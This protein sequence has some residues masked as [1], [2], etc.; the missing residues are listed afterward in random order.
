MDLTRAELDVVVRRREYAADDVV[1]LTLADPRGAELPDWAPG[2]HI[3]LLMTPSLI[4]QYSL[5]GEPANRTEWRVGVLLDPNSR[6][7]SQ[8]VH[9]RLREGAMVRVR[10]PRNHFPLVS[11]PRYLFIAGGIGITPILPMITAAEAAGSQ[12]QLLYGGRTRSSMPYLDVLERHGRRV[13]ICCRDKR[14]GPDFRTALTA[15]LSEPDGNTGVYC[16]GPEGLL[17]AVGTA[18][19]RWPDN[20]LHVERFSARSRD[21]T[22]EGL[23]SFEL[24]CRRSGVTFTVAQDQSIYQACEIAGVDVLGSCMEGVCGTCESDI[25]E[26]EL[27]HRDSVLNDAE[28][29]A[30]ETMMIC[31]SRARSQRLVLDL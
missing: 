2:A 20:S 12:W 17:E 15:A 23:T 18:C 27:D 5:C 11:S 13:T 26:G 14:E 3:D 10:L 29:D 8:F 9:D 31:V 19:E 24:E 16:C 7:G 30:N 6:G 25:I 22:V 4:R 21:D 1:T 28:Q